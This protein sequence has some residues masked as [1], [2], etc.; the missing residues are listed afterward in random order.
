MIYGDIIDKAILEVFGD[1]T[2]QASV[3]ANMYGSEGIVGT[4]QRQ[5]QEEH[6]Y[7]FMLADTTVTLIDATAAY[8]LNLAN[9][10][11]EEINLHVV[12]QDSYVYDPLTKI[13]PNQA[14]V[15]QAEETEPTHYW[16]DY[17]GTYRR[18]NLYPTP[19]VDAGYTRTLHLRYWKYLTKLSDTDAT[20]DAY[21]DDISVQAPWYLIY[22]SA[23]ML[24]STIESYEKMQIMEVRA[25]EQLQKLNKK[26]SRYKVANFYIPYRRI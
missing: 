17:G 21:S 26:D 14:D 22:K 23:A 20:L 9:E 15:L 12:D 10:F 13:T 5:L 19:N 2:P 4:I 1:D 25:T 18:L 8:D 3:L 24:C 7:W 16:I 6:N 11:K